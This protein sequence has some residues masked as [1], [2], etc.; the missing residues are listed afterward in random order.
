MSERVSGGL[1]PLGCVCGGISQQA[2]GLLRKV[3]EGRVVLAIS[4]A[5]LNHGKEQITGS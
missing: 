5:S 2:S 3:G 1:A 4:K